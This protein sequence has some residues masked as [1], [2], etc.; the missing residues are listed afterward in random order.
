MTPPR[1]IKLLVTNL[2][3]GLLEDL[4]LFSSSV[5]C[6]L[7]EL[8]AEN[9]LLARAFE[10]SKVPTAVGTYI[11]IDRNMKQDKNETHEHDRNVT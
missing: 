3:E 5:T 11:K 8:S 6:R 4:L 9:S 1:R 7:S 10:L 2:Q